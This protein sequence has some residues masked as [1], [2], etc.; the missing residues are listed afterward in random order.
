MHHRRGYVSGKRGPDGESPALQPVRSTQPDHA[1][2]REA[3]HLTLIVERCDNGRGV[4][5]LIAGAFPNHRAGAFLEA[6][7]ARAVRSPDAHNQVI[8]VHLGGSVV[9]VAGGPGGVAGFAHEH[10]LMVL[11]EA[12]PPDQRAIGRVAALQFSPAGDGV[13]HVVVDDGRV[14]GTGGSLG[15]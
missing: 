15:V 4:A 9:A 3:N 6:D 13:D 10:S 8:A 11:H 7:H 14:A 5:R 2:C 1:G 12:G